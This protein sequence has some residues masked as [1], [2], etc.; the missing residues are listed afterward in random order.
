MFRLT[1]TRVAARKR[2]SNVLSLILC[3]LIC[4]LVQDG[5]VRMCVLD[6]SHL[7]ATSHC[8]IFA[9]Y[10]FFP[11]FSFF[12]LLECCSRSDT[13]MSRLRCNVDLEKRYALYGVKVNSRTFDSNWC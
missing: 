10:L 6:A 9:Q 5:C 3:S 1:A 13:P 12:F 8:D 4:M 7:Q 11:F 2:S